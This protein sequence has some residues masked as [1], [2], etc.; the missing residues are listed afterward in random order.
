MPFRVIEHPADLGIEVSAADRASLFAEAAYGLTHLIN[1]SSV[2]S[3]TLERSV[4]VEG[5]DLAQLMVRWLNEVLFLF[6]SERFLVSSACVHFDRSLQLS[7][8]LTGEQ[9]DPRRHANLQEIKAVTYHHITV[10]ESAAGWSA[11]VFF[12]V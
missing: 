2:L 9:A 12:D 3:A 1:P 8:T 4:T 11:T 5:A 7:A 10:T 6:D